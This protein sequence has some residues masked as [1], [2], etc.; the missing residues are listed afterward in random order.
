MALFFFFS[1][2][3][4]NHARSE[5]RP[6]GPGGDI[7]HSPSPNN[8]EIKKCLDTFFNSNIIREDNALMLGA[9]AIHDCNAKPGDILMYLQ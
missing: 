9:K 5:D 1:C 8:H 2:S 3:N 7:D 6:I 4:R